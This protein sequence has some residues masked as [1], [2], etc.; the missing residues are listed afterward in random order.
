M[1]KRS[2]R[3]VRRSPTI[4]VWDRPRTFCQSPY[5]DRRARSDFRLLSKAHANVARERQVMADVKLLTFE[6]STP[7]QRHEYE[8]TLG[9]WIDDGYEI[10]GMTA[11]EYPLNHI[12]VVTLVRH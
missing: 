4:G 6:F 10:A 7:Q 11:V 9:Q 1:M 8:T 5:D 2:R 12:L 3:A